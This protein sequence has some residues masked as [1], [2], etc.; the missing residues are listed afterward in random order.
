VELV[1]R[2]PSPR[3]ARTGET[4]ELGPHFQGGLVAFSF[5]NVGQ[6]CLVHWHASVELRD[7]LSVRAEVQR[8]RPAAAV[9]GII[10]LSIGAEAGFP[11]ASIANA[12]AECV[13]ALRTECSVL[14]VAI[15]GQDAHRRPF[16]ALCCGAEPASPGTRV[17]QVRAR[18]IEFYDSL[19]GA[20]VAARRIAPQDALRLQHLARVL[21]RRGWQ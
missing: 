3:V 1:A 4:S 18:L 20:L 12:F 7:L 2:A 9:Q 19:D 10:V 15:E 6:V 14:L 16:R 13:S 5:I 8:S 11:P 21:T 17:T